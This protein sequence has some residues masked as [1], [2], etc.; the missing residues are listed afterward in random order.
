[1]NQHFQNVFKTFMNDLSMISK[2]Q[3]CKQIVLTIIY[4]PIRPSR[5]ESEED[6]LDDE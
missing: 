1:M 4:I 5:R 6:E 2:Y 3:I